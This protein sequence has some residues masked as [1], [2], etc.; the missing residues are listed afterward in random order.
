MQLS[1]PEV[2]LVCTSA[3]VGGTLPMAVGAALSATIRRSGQVAVVVFGDG[4]T[5]E[6]VFHESLNFASL[7]RLPVVFVCENNFYAC[8]SHQ[9]D[10]QPADNIAQR[11]ASYAMPGVRV[12]GNDVAAVFRAVG[13][14]VERARQARGPSL[15][16]C[17]TYR[18]REH[19]GPHDDTALG[20]RSVTEVRRWKAQC[21]IQR[22]SRQLKRE[23]LLTAEEEARRIDTIRRELDEAVAF[24]K[25]SEEPDV[26]ELS[27]YV[28][29]ESV[30]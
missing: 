15:I 29:A 20:Y 2:G 13:R 27:R 21:P 26:A 5:E 9:L 6:G 16:E 22:L 19:V 25:A 14:A 18:W 30:S 1:A 28:Y 12:D 24:A 17:R 10:R 8:Y 3:I 4:A 23:G 7:K 11:A